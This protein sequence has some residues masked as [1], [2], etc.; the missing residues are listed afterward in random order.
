MDQ[1]VLIGLMGFLILGSIVALEMRHLLSAVIAVGVVGLGLSILFLLLGAPD[2]AI[3]QVVVDIL[4][5]TVLIRAAGRTTG[6]PVGKRHDKFALVGGLA[7]MICL[8]VFLIHAFQA[9]PPFGAPTATLSNYYLQHGPE[10][11]ML[12]SCCIESRC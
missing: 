9:L 7:L 8:F 3:T 1:W 12:H 2:I 4:V 5:V 6:E 11:T 10:A